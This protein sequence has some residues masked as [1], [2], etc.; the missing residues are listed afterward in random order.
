MIP[1]GCGSSKKCRNL[2]MNDGRCSI[3]NVTVGCHLF[4]RQH[5]EGPVFQL[6]N[7]VRFADERWHAENCWKQIAVKHFALWGSRELLPSRFVALKAS[8]SPMRRS[9]L[10][11][12]EMFLIKA[13]RPVTHHSFFSKFIFWPRVFSEIAV[14]HVKVGFDSPWVGTLW[15]A[16]EWF[17]YDHM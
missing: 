8:N 3:Q 16:W 4:I 13:A 1:Q 14:W 5:F 2:W 9:R 15:N 7:S 10:H 12:T 6:D 11:K 17:M